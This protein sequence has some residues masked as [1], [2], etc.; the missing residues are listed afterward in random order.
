[1]SNP[2]LASTKSIYLKTSVVTIP[3]AG[4]RYIV[5]NFLNSNQIIKISSLYI[6]QQAAE[7][8]MPNPLAINETY[9]FPWAVQTAGGAAVAGTPGTPG[10]AGTASTVSHLVKKDAVPPTYDSKGVQTSPGSPPEYDN[11]VVPGINATAGTAGTAGTPG[12]AGTG[13]IIG[14]AGS[15]AYAAGNWTEV[16][17]TFE[18]TVS[19]IDTDANNYTNCN[20][21]DGIGS[22]D[23]ASN[24]L[25]PHREKLI[26]I[27]RDAPI[28]L[29]E[30]D[31]IK[32]TVI[33][34]GPV[35]VVCCYEKV[36]NFEDF[37]VRI[38]GD[39]ISIWPN[40]KPPL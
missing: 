17:V 29:S 13:G 1:M 39:T 14:P 5:K 23:L 30:G 31:S 37:E 25:V 3:A 34:G 18:R 40:G 16:A 22:Y 10:T 38:G 35:Q 6:S 8:K 19:N 26:A 21:G 33:R 27:E 36:T 32:I 9:T 28:Y 24:L 11:V 2:N 20:L 15:P 12:W 7:Q 4:T